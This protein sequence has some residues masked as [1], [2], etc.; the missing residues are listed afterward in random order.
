MDPPAPVRCIFR[1]SILA[2]LLAANPA[3]TLLPDSMAR[4]LPSSMESGSISNC[5][6]VVQVF[7]DWAPDL[8]FPGGKNL[9]KNLSLVEVGGGGG[10]SNSSP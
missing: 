7:P 1:S 3:L 10:G 5:L 8:A 4:V 6:L 9:P 2:F